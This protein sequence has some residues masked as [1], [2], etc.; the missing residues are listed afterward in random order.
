MKAMYLSRAALVALTIGAAG[1]GSVVREGTGTSFLILNSLQA[2]SGAQPG[3]F[4][5][6]LNSDV[7]TVVDGTP[8]V[9]NDLAQVTFELGLKDPGGAGSP[10]SPTQNQFITIDRYRVEYER[11]DNRNT[12]GVDVP[13]AFDGSITLTVGDGGGSAGFQLVRHLA[14]GEAPLK[15][16]ANSQVIISTV[17]K[18]TFF[19]RDQTGHEVTAS[20]KISIDFGNFG[21]PN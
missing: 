5:G 16:L 1:C 17:A 15:A 14:K 20:G 6:T 19:G 10:N 18:V 4:G 13:Y 8:T 11:A 7:I 9:F 12:Q 21:D 2:A 3:E